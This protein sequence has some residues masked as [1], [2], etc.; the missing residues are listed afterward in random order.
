MRARTTRVL[1][2]SAVVVVSLSLSAAPNRDTDRLRGRE[3]D[4]SAIAKI[5][6]HVKRGIAS[7]GDTLTVPHP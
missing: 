3:R 1:V 5:V 6:K 2:L 4:E 7:L